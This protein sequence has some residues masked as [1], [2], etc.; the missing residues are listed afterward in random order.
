ME[1]NEG[2]DEEGT[3]KERSGVDEDAATASL[4]AIFFQCE[5][6]KDTA[7][8][9]LDA[10]SECGCPSIYNCGFPLESMNSQNQ[11]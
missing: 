4:T 7:S 5:M 11:G 1:D 9:T 8:A 10:L 3:R 6:V 2:E